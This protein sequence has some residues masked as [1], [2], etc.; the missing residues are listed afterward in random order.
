[1]R[2]QAFRVE[3]L[4]ADFLGPGLL[5][6]IASDPARHVLAAV[7]KGFHLRFG[8]SLQRLDAAFFLLPA[9]VLVHRVH[10]GR[11]LFGTERDARA[12]F[13]RPSRPPC[14]MD[15]A[16]HVLWHVKIEDGSHPS[17]IDAPDHAVLPVLQTPLPLRRD[18]APSLAMGRAFRR[19]AVGRDQVV[20][21]ALVE[22][23]QDVLSGIERELR[24]QHGA[25]HPEVFEEELDLV[26]R[27]DAVDED[28]G[29]LRH[30][31]H[32]EGHGHAEQLVFA[33]A[34]NHEMF[35]RFG[36]ARS[37]GLP[38]LF[39]LH[40]DD[41]WVVQHEFF[42]LFHVFVERG[43]HE[44]AL[45]GPGH[46]RRDGTQVLSVPIREQ[47]VG[48]VEDQATESFLEHLGRQDA[49][50]HAV[51]NGGRRGDHHFFDGGECCFGGG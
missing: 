51:R 15:V 9:E 48:F 47:Q 3:K 35:Y 4:H 32:L 26:S 22:F 24:V 12:G 49:F 25:P 39:G 20:E 13:A 19:S 8:Q 31:S 36:H 37:S 34:C 1:M 41:F 46:V 27:V 11:L 28:E 38:S 18:G 44:Q 16:V 33:L 43:G 50:P 10:E 5:D 30:Q 6:G 17:K 29:F 2:L 45:A 14:S 7:P 40:V 21:E 42:Q 23:L